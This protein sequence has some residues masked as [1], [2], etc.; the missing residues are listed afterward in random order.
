[1]SS[2]LWRLHAP[3]HHVQGRGADEGIRP[4]TNQWPGVAMLALPDADVD[5][6]LQI[7]GIAGALVVDL[8]VG[9]IE[10]IST[11]GILR[12]GVDLHPGG[13]H[14]LR[15]RALVGSKHGKLSA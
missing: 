9:A 6:Y 11:D 1:M 5:I 2:Q 13:G 15:R 3:L 8:V 10:A 4:Y 12:Q 7:L 14:D